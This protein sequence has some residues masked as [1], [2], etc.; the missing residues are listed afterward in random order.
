M[1]FIVD[2][3]LSP[4]LAAWLVKKGHDATHALQAGL[5]RSSDEEILEYARNEKRIIITADLDFPRLL[6]IVQTE[7]P[8]LILFRGGDYSEQEAIE[9]LTH[10]LESIPHEELP[11]SIIIIEKGRIRR[12]R[13]PI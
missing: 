3:P 5:N 1:K 10:V 6:A 13:L 9:R 4:E 11:N 7:D 8:G 12:R 2:M